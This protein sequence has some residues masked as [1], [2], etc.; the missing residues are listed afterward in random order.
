MGGQ[1]VITFIII[2]IKIIIVI[3]ITI[4][5]RAGDRAVEGN[6]WRVVGRTG[7]REQDWA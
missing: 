1:E 4:I 2:N 5:I 7:Q 6:L 3:I